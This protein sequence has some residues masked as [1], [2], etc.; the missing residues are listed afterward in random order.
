MIERRSQTRNPSIDTVLIVDDEQEW[1]E[2]L[3]RRLGSI[4]RL[5]LVANSIR[6]CYQRLSKN[7]C[8]VVIIGNKLPDGMGFDEIDNIQKLYPNTKVVVL[9]AYERPEKY[10]PIAVILS[11]L[12]DIDILVKM[13]ELK[14]DLNLLKTRLS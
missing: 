2:I 13:L 9:T 4:A 7:T 10:K 8:D 3:K 14:G 5:I 11:K 6:E 1:V 12:S